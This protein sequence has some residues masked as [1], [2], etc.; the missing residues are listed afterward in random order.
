MDF[1]TLLSPSEL[2]LSSVKISFIPAFLRRVGEGE[3]EKKKVG[4][5]GRKRE[6]ESD[7]IYWHCLDSDSNRSLLLF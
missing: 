1:M 4:E 7:N 5:R 6:V 2:P 3:I